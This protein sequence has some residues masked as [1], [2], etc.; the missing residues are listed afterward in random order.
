M[1]GLFYQW[2]F[3]YHQ[4]IG[5]FNR[6]RRLQPSRPGW[7]LDFN[8][9]LS[10]FVRWNWHEPSGDVRRDTVKYYPEMALE[11]TTLAPATLVMD[12]TLGQYNYKG[13]MLASEDAYLYGWF[14]A[15]VKTEGQACWPAFWMYT[16]NGSD[17]WNEIDI[18]EFAPAN[19]GK[20][21][22]AHHHD[23][24]SDVEKFAVSNDWHS[25]WHYY[26]FE[27]RPNVMRWYI[28]DICINC[29]CRNIP[30]HPMIMLLSLEVDPE[31]RPQQLPARMYIDYVRRYCL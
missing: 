19:N 22:I 14:E 20:F 10:D 13:G 11:K 16:A 15:R 24:R 31:L 29:T 28:D 3:W 26:S 17:V 8:D 7:T 23:D 4:T 5:S 25:K 9:E 12:F 6:E 2:Y 1:G 30:Q 18:M 21:N 27:W